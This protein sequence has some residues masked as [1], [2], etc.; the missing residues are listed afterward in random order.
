M[1]EEASVEQ[2]FEA[3][4][5]APWGTPYPQQSWPISEDWAWP[6]FRPWESAGADHSEESVGTDRPE[7]CSGALRAQVICIDIVQ[8]RN[9]LFD[10]LDGVIACL[11]VVNDALEAVLPNRKHRKRLSLFHNV[12]GLLGGG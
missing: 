1:N 5:I 9:D 12:L 8:Q 3:P 10:V 11:T 6:E 2:Q 7:D 4:E